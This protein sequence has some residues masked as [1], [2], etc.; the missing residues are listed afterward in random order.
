MSKE[1]PPKKIALKSFE[2]F[3]KITSHLRKIEDINDTEITK[4][5]AAFKDR[6]EK[7]VKLVKEKGIMKYQFIPSRITRWV[8]SGQGKEYLVIERN[9]CSCRDFLFNVL[10]RREIST[11]YH[12]LARELA[13]Q[14]NEFEEIEISDE[15]YLEYMNKWL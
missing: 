13:E 11:C 3:P 12:L 10:Y 7:A 14:V 8:V 4:L 9:F 15:L 5:K 1:A 2:I 6:A